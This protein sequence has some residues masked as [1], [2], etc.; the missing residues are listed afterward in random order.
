MH[1]FEKQNICDETH[2]QFPSSYLP[3]I[4]NSKVNSAIAGF[5]IQNWRVAF[6]QKRKNSM[7]YCLPAKQHVHVHKFAGRM[8]FPRISAMMLLSPPKYS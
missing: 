3:S 8:G 6:L 5:V 2:L 1:I 7:V 4:I